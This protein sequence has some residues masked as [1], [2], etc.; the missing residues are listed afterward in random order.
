MHSR[1]G[2]K[3]GVSYYALFTELLLINLCF[4]GD[5]YFRAAF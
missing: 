2:T 5:G 4:A 1:E 3:E